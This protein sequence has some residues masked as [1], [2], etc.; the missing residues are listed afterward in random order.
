MTSSRSLELE[1]RQVV[2]L[3]GFARVAE[4]IAFDPDKTT[5][6][7]RRFDRLSARNL[8]FL[9]AELAELEHSLS[10]HDLEDS[11][12]NLLSFETQSDW[13]QFAQNAVQKDNDGHPASPRDKEKM[14]LA[15]RIRIKLKEYREQALFGHQVS[16]LHTMFTRSL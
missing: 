2:R 15:M 12:R 10:K 16:L 4:K 11:R 14:D 1:E 9:Q 3:K 8:L 13:A 6:I 7:Y 5:T